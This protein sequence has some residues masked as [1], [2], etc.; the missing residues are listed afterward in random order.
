MKVNPN[1]PE[2]I[3]GSTLKHYNQHAEA[4]WQGTRD[5]DVSQNIEALLTSIDGEPPFTIL[6]FGCG[7]GRDLKA[8]RDLGHIAIGLDGGGPFVSMARSYSSCEVWQQ[9]FLKLDLPAAYFDGIFAN[10]ALFHVPAQ[11]LP[12]VLRDLHAALK[13]AGVLFSSKSARPQ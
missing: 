7:P 12:R 2:H 8:F 4:F 1:D 5:H 3:A 9:D 6:D 11:E 10:A 13:P